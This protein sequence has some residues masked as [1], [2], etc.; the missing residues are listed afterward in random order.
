MGYKVVSRY[1][2]VDGKRHIYNPHGDEVKFPDDDTVDRHKLESSIAE[3]LY[4]YNNPR[5]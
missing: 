3:N 4:L 1:D 5:A 2:S